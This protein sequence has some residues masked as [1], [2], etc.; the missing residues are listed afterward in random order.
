MGRHPNGRRPEPGTPMP[1][2]PAPKA[3]ASKSSAAKSSAAKSAATKPPA[4]KSPAAKPAAPKAKASAPAATIWH[5]PSCS[6]SRNT[7]ALLREA[8]IEPAIVQYLKTPPSRAEIEKA[9]KAAGLTVRGAMRKKGPVYEELGLN[10]PSL[11]DAALLDA[12]AAHP[13]LIERPF[14]FTQK[15]VRLARPIDLVREIL[16]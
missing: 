5:N 15:G 1:K 4:A 2:S 13:V 11:T 7:L 9:I 10:D 3:P 16:P 14:V 8:G 12:M 6:T